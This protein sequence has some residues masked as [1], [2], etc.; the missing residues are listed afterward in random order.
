MELQWSEWRERAQDL[1]L[2]LHENRGRDTNQLRDMDM[3]S[4]G[5]E[6]AEVDW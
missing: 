5:K 1:V 3:V 6:N 2:T 4:A